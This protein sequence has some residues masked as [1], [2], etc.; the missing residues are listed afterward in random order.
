MVRGS[1]M[2]RGALRREGWEWEKNGASYDSLA[3]VVGCSMKIPAPP[4]AESTTFPVQI[5]NGVRVVSAMLKYM[6]HISVSSFFSF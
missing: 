6:H 4:P 2:S 3:L 1:G 5:T